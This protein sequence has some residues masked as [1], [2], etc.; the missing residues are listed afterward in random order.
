MMI[1]CMAGK[2]AALH[3]TVYDASPFLFNEENTAINY[4]GELLQAGH[5]YLRCNFFFLTFIITY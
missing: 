2:S 1:E 4:F 5:F 3:G